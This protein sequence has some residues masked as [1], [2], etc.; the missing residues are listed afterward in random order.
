MY[1]ENG[2]YIITIDNLFS[3]ASKRNW[4]AVLEDARFL[5]VELGSLDLSVSNEAPSTL[6]P[7]PS[8]IPFLVR[9]FLRFFGF[10][11]LDFDR[12]CAPP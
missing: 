12:F 3:T 8:N 2:R 6:F 11:I 4:R 9:G 1:I 7:E 5:N 10:K